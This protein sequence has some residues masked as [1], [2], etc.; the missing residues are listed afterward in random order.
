M[1]EQEKKIISQFKEIES[2]L[3][4][5]SVLKKREE[6]T[7]LSKERARLLPIA[8]ILKEQ[9]KFIE[10]LNEIQ[11]S[12]SQED[13]KELIE[14]LEKEKTNIK[15][16]LEEL[17]K[18]LQLMLLPKDESSGKN[19]FV[20]IRAGTGGEEAALF[21]KDILRMYSRFL[22]NEKIDFQIIEVQSTGLYGVKEAIILVKGKRAY[23]LMHLEA[24]GHRVQRI[25][26]TESG[27]RIHT[28]A[29]TVAVILEVSEEE[30]EINANDLRIDVFRSSGP[31]GQS[32]N[33]TDSAVR[34]THVPSGLTVSCQDEKSQH[35]NKAKAMSILRARLKNKELEEKNKKAAIEKKA[36]IGSGDRSEKI[37]TYNFPQ[38]RITDHRINYTSHNLDKVIEGDLGE[39]IQNLIKAEKAVKLDNF[40]K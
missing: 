30:F 31:G 25:P 14:L 40:N 37:R 34:I 33:T 9:E 24:G 15:E 2:R 5:P 13:N 26:E 32:V 19:I 1:N 29:C 39:L 7:N 12:Q 16:K 10:Q 6:F 3:S 27:G 23:D 36:Q 4:E 38:N 17:K 20:E 21:A 18:N 8:Q 28:S 11:T 35:K 22:E